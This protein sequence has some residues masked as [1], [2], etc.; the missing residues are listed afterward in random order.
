MKNYISNY[1]LVRQN[2]IIYLKAPAKSR[3]QTIP[4]TVVFSG[5]AKVELLRK[6]KGRGVSSESFIPF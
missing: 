3:L 1:T 6:A 2:S 4:Y 5:L